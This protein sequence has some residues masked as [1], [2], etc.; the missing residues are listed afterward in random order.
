MQGKI[1]KQMKYLRL[2]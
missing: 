2:V 1:E